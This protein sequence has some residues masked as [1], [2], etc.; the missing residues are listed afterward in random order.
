MTPRAL[1]ADMTPASL[2]L[3]LILLA[4]CAAALRVDAGESF[5]SSESTTEELITELDKPI[6]VVDVQGVLGKKTMLPCDIAPRDRDDH[7]H[8]VLW[9]KEADGEPL[10]SFDVRGGRN[11]GK[12]KLWSSPTAFGQRA[13]FRT[14]S[15]PAQLLVDDL[16]LSDEGVYRCRVDFRDSPTRNLNINLTVIVPPERP[17]IYDAKRRDRTKILEPYNEGSDVTLVCEVTGGRPKPKVTWFLENTVID[18]SFE[19]RA[20][21]VTANHLNFPNV[22]RQHLHGRLVCQAFNTALAPPA[23]KVVV[24]DINL[25]PVSVHILT[26]EKQVS[27]ERKYEVECRS[28]GSRPEAIITWWKGSR[29]IKRIT[30]TFSEDGGQNLSILSF[31]P[32]IDDD[33]KYLTCRAENPAIPDSALEDKWRLNVQYMPVVTLKMGSSLNPDDIKE[34]DDVYFEC[35]IRANPKPYRLAWY[36]NGREMHHNVSAGVILSDQSLV[37]QGVTKHSAG[38]YTCLAANIE[39]KGSSNPVMLRVMYAPACREEREELLGALKHETVSLKCEVDANPPPAS[40]HWTFNNS[41]DLAEVPA[42]KFTASG[43]VSRLNYTPASDMDYGTLACWGSNAVGHQRAPCIFQ[44]VAAGRPF[45]LVNCSVANQTADSLHVEC[46]EGF[47]GGLPQSFLLELLE[48]PGLRQRFNV[49]V[50]RGPPVFDVFGTDPGASYRAR[51]YA[52]NAKGR[53]EPVFIEPVTFK[54]VA[55]FLGPSAPAPASP[56]LVALL[57]TAAALAL[58]VCAVVAALCR[59]YRRR[60][61][62]RRPDKPRAAPPPPHGDASS[63]A[64]AGVGA[65]CAGAVDGGCPWVDHSTPLNPAAAE[66]T[67]PDIIPTKYERRPLKGF[68]KMYKTPPQRRRRKSAAGGEEEEEE[69]QADNSHDEG[70]RRCDH[71]VVDSKAQ[72]MSNST[73]LLRAHKGVATPS[74]LSEVASLASLQDKLASGAVTTSPRMQESCI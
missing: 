66:D 51:L 35:N 37:L 23:S 18:D 48:L 12:A 33:G 14:T 13:Y 11:F 69:D 9:F 24:L 56:V 73:P 44:V 25:K 30:K 63:G 19:V 59:R 43:G 71:H 45:P 6:P 26:K 15:S 50:A 27:A 8:M 20:D 17:V 57:A 52:V 10:Y 60:L 58:L 40:F 39:G 47:D 2:L 4:A 72:L 22:G 61:R 64:A 16:R 36:H 65:G 34:G 68:M 46:A 1:L 42:S 5:L 49:T 32:V 67:D 62:A 54:G 29:Q 41:G 31:V 38:E 74:P 70:T 55:K 53:S 3:V 7:V 21:G 28:A